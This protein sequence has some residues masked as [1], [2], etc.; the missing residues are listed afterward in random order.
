M[1]LL[2]LLLLW[3]NPLVVLEVELFETIDI[4]LLLLIEGFKEEDDVGL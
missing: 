4:D 2:L 3:D 1:L